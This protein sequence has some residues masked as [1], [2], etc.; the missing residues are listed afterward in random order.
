[1]KNHTDKKNIKFLKITPFINKQMKINKKINNKRNYKNDKLI[2]TYK[3]KNIYNVHSPYKTI[4]NERH[5]LYSK[6]DKNNCYFNKKEPIFNTP[7]KSGIKIIPSITNTQEKI[8]NFSKTSKTSKT[9]FQVHKNIFKRGKKNLD[10]HK[11]GDKYIDNEIEKDK[12]NNNAKNCKNTYT[13]NTFNF[14]SFNNSINNVQINNNIYTNINNNIN[15]NFFNNHTFNNNI[16]NNNTFNNNIFNKKNVNKKMDEIKTSS[17]NFSNKSFQNNSSKNI[18]NNINININQSSY[19]LNTIS[20]FCHKLKYNYSNNKRCSKNNHFIYLNSKKNNNLQIK[21]QRSKKLEINIQLS[22]IKLKELKSNWYNNRKKKRELL[23]KTNNSNLVSPSHKKNEQYFYRCNTNNSDNDK[24]NNRKRIFS[25]ENIVSKNSN[26]IT[27]DNKNSKSQSCSTNKRTPKYRFK[28]SDTF[29]VES[30]NNFNKLEVFNTK[31]SNNILPIVPDIRKHIKSTFDFD[32]AIETINSSNTNISQNNITNNIKIINEKQI[33]QNIN[34]R[35]HK[36]SKNILAEMVKKE[37]DICHK[38]IDSHLF[39]IHYNSHPS[40]IFEWLY[41]GSF[42][43]ACDIDE[44]RKNK[45]NYVLNCAIECHNQKLPK[46][47]KELHLNI[48]DQ[49]DFELINYFEES[50]KFIN[51]CKLEGGTMLVHCKLGV[52]RSASFVIAYLIENNKLSTQKALKFVKEKRKQIKPNDG[53]IK[54]LRKYERIIY[55]RKN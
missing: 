6:N 47:I 5:S 12:D 45:I 46:D 36:C 50:N 39:K 52:S 2:I 8:H 27:I 29:K 35:R 37:C 25:N 54:Q 15:N 18:I 3:N 33:I 19:N 16:L 4:N 40:Q 13:I 20:D 1:M 17:E 53:F 49:N 30:R 7:Q 28:S 41:L 14:N 34:K 32:S 26:Q 51:E 42:I 22:E 31:T 9:F 38:F 10:A 44:L 55:L 43:N 21:N 11:L 48:K 23:N 24:L